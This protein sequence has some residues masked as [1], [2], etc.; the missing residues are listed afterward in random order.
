MPTSLQGALRHLN[1][2]Q[3]EAVTGTSNTLV[4]AGPGSGKTDTIVTKVAS[5]LSTDVRAPRG[6]ACITYSNDAAREFTTRL[7]DSGVRSGRRLFLGT[8][9]SFCLTRVI[10]PYAHLTGDESLRGRGV[11]GKAGRTSLLQRSL[12]AEAVAENAAYFGEHIK[13]RKALACGESVE[14]FDDRHVAV[15]RKYDSLLSQ[16]GMLDFDALTFQAL[17]MVR[18][19]EAVRDLL[20][21][22]FPWIAVDEYQDLGGVL[23]TLLMILKESGATIFA[24]G[25]PDQCIFGFSG[26]SPRYL[27]ALAKSPDFQVIRL[28]VNY[29]SGQK[30]IDAAAGALGE[31]RKYVA[32]DARKALGEVVLLRCA[33]GLAAQAS[34]IALSVVP[35]LIASGVPAHE[36]AMLYPR[37]GTLLQLVL[38][39]LRA[40]GIPAHWEK[41]ITFPEA[42]VVRWLQRSAAWSLKP[43]STDV[44]YSTEVLGPYVSML[45]SAESVSSVAL[46]ERAR[47]AKALDLRPRPSDDFESWLA[48]FD[49]LAGV[50]TLVADDPTSTE[51]A[52]ALDD[53]FAM[54]ETKN[55]SM[56]DFARTKPPR[57]HVLVTTY[58]SSKGRQFDAVVLPG[59]Q[60][61]LV[62]HAHW[63]R[64]LR[65]MVESDVPG[66][67]R[68]FYVALT[69]ARDHAILCYSARF[70]NDNGYPVEGPSRFVS[71]LADH[72]DVSL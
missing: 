27:D 35:Q 69:R 26:A 23:H 4:L 58:H 38:E 50:R 70:H 40:A 28:H 25:D 44:D 29:R 10:R 59:L 15:A 39:H 17:R 68:L 13:I 53:L 34:A 12:D 61:T 63:D 51:D 24:V 2:E 19:S 62:P 56:K 32:D 46:P 47:L 45:H 11:I 14:H 71:Q 8:L 20:V 37:K 55:I 67:R 57:D 30:L 52:E 5:L 66:D 72:L 49:D 21:A 43:G 31:T 22:R 64:N 36:I 65:Q 16:A 41:D 6:V 60:T 3:I 7:R 54:A 33:D 42:L 48:R 18:T 1:D 9:H